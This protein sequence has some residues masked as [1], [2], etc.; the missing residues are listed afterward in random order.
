[1]IEIFGFYK[2][3]NINT[4]KRNKKV[5]QN[6]LINT[7]SRGTIII[8]KEGI[9]GSISGQSINIKKLITKIKKLFKFNK[10]DSFPLY[11]SCSRF[12]VVLQIFETTN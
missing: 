12:S 9:N 8:S 4:L 5:L 2:F 6:F 1:M 10:F 3:I 7:N 11:R